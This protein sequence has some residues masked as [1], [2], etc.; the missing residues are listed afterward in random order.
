MAPDTN[1]RRPQAKAGVP[2]DDHGGGNV[3]GAKVA[4]AADMRRRREAAHRLPPLA[5]DY[6][7][8]IDMLAGLPI[9][10]GTDICRGEFGGGGRWRPCCGR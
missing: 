10:T 6:R 9:R 8:P 5:T 1:E 4:V 2:D 3:L 7:D